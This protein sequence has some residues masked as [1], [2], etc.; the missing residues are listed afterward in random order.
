[1]ELQR[2]LNGAVAGAVAAAV[3]AA[4]Q[5]LDKRAF[6]SSYDDVELL[7]KLAT[8]G[9]S[10][11]AAGVA[12]HLQNG[13]VFGALYTHLRPFLPGPGLP[14]KAPPGRRNGRPGRNLRSVRL[15][16]APGSLRRPR[17]SWS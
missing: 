15:P 10:W 6:E 11:P 3:W 13:A 7:G 17:R 9:S 8:R 5:P 4:Q 16:A 14:Q 2:T 12:L 1:M